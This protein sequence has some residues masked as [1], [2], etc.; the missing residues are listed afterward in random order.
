MLNLT[1]PT[2]PDRIYRVQSWSNLDSPS[3]SDVLTDL[4]G[5]GGDM[6][7]QVPVGGAQMFYRVV[8]DPQ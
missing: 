2:V 3:F 6:S 8:L 7:V 4:N 1:W 5:D